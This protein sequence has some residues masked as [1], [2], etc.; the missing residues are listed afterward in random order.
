MHKKRTVD[1]KMF[2]NKSKNKRQLLRICICQQNV[3]ISLC[4]KIYFV[5]M[6]KGILENS[7]MNYHKIM[8]GMLGPILSKYD[9]DKTSSFASDL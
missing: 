2:E 9:N 6:R 3:Y 5:I 4:V 1:L 7:S 8:I